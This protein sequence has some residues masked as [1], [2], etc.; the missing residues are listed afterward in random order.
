MDEIATRSSFFRILSLL[1]ELSLRRVRIFGR[2]NT[3][4]ELKYGSTMVLEL[5]GRVELTGS[6]HIRKLVTVRGSILLAELVAK[7]VI[8]EHLIISSS[9]I[10][11][12]RLFGSAVTQW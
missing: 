1:Y 4:H 8:L 5:T 2:S 6:K 10:M 9:G 11:T 7:L 3:R 12:L